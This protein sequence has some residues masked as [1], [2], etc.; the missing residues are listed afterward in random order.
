[1]STPVPE[2]PSNQTPDLAAR[3]KRSRRLVGIVA[4]AAIAVGGGS[5]AAKQLSSGE[6]HSDSYSRV[7]PG[8]IATTPTA[9]VTPSQS[10]KPTKNLIQ[11]I[12]Q[13]PGYGKQVSE[14][15][16]Q[17]MRTSSVEVVTTQKDTADPYSTVGFCTGI[18]VSIGGQSYVATARHCLISQDEAVGRWPQITTSSNP[19][20]DPALHSVDNITQDVKSL[21]KE[22]SVYT[23]G[24]NGD[25]DMN[26]GVAVESIAGSYYPDMALLKAAP[27]S[28]TTTAFDKLPAID[29]EN[30]L[31]DT[32]EAGAQAVI[33][34]TPTSAG[35]RMIETTGTYLGVTSD[36]SDSARSLAW[37][38]IDGKDATKDGCYWGGSGSAAYIAGAGITGPLYGRNHPGD[39]DAE[40]GEAGRR[41]HIVHELGIDLGATN[42]TL[43][44]FS[45]INPDIATTMAHVADRE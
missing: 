9:H 15:E 42:T 29:Y 3:R 43:C 8:K 20:H 10:E 22:V 24:A 45:I 39:A 37:V 38:A 14:Q 4:T 40:Q 25:P 12:E 6:E 41:S 44:G 23:V 2:S 19:G 13:L 35:P 11:T 33:Y 5:L 7:I 30:L 32:A 16:R 21:R 17:L 27:S 36:P 34:S 28:A 1:M 31:S 26:N 18:K